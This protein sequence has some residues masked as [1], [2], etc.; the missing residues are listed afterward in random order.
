MNTR[1]LTICQYQQSIVVNK[2]KG[3]WFPSLRG[4]Y[5]PSFDV[6]IDTGLAINWLG[7]RVR[8]SLRPKMGAL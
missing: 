8:V 7:I 3:L 5:L 2:V 4:T 1:F 6:Q